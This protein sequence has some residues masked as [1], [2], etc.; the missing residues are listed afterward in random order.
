MRHPSHCHITITVLMMVHGQ[1]IATK[2]HVETVCTQSFLRYLLSFYYVPS[3]EDKTWWAK[4][5]HGPC[6]MEYT[7][8]GGDR[9][10]QKEI[11]F[12]NESQQAHCKS[13]EN[14]SKANIISSLYTQPRSSL[15]QETIFPQVGLSDR[16]KI[17]GFHW[18]GGSLSAPGSW[19]RVFAIPLG[20]GTNLCARLQHPAEHRAKNVPSVF[21][22]YF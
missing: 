7:I 20:S 8:S 6:L 3:T 2:V 15:T 10:N 22:G 17:E 9:M 21:F 16:P 11:F 18:P 14:T 19:N 4:K 1:S 12:T 5:R 13:H